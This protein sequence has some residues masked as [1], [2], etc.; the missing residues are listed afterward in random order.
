MQTQIVLLGL[1]VRSTLFYQEVLHNLYNKKFK[2]FSTCP[3][4]VK[5]IDFNTINPYLPNG[6][7]VIIPILQEA[8]MPFNS[9]KT[10]LIVPNITLH[11]ILDLMSFKLCI[12]HPII[13][14]EHKLIETSLK[15]CVVFGTRHTKGNSSIAT[16][17]N[18]TE[19]TLVNLDEDIISFLD[20]LRQAVYY[21]KE[22][23]TN[24]AKFKA[25]VNEFSTN[26][27]VIIACTELSII[28]TNHTKNV[29]D[30]VQLQCNAII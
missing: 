6:K 24:V 4:I 27:L 8:I 23:S 14:L 5:Q 30:L 26:C 2:G 1:G 3:L 18:N 20:E 21:N 17:L 16:V 19:T 10:N 11:S 29:I 7:N 25:L 15:T 28:N 13:L 9:F 22:T 12:I